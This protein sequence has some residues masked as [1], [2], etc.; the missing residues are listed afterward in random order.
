[1][2]SFL[3]RIF[4][5]GWKVFRSKLLISFFSTL[6][7]VLI[8]VFIWQAVIVNFFINKG[9]GYIE[10]KLDF[11]IYFKD[12]TEQD[13]IKKLQ[14]ILENFPNIDRV[15]LVNKER[16]FEEFKKEIEKNPVIVQAL[17][18]IQVNPLSDYLIVRGQNPKIYEEIANY[19]EGSPYRSLIEFV[20]YAENQKIIQ[21]FIN[22][23]Q[24]IKFTLGLIIVFVG[25]FCA[26][27]I[28]NLTILIIYSQKDEIEVLKLI[29]ASNFFVRSP[30]L[31]FAL[32]VTIFGFLLATLLSIIIIQNINPVF[33]TMIP[34]AD[35]EEYIFGNFWK[36]SGTIFGFLLFINLVSTWL[37]LQKYLKI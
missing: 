26:L 37:S 17:E 2:I 15:M 10:K 7:V 12:G 28:F 27:V 13:D 20:T 35:L 11:S 32:I 3:K 16:A 6:T 9:L 14:A 18:A 29:G 5:N 8:G 19:L 33:L 25:V 31:V 24:K 1:M 4:Q 34:A 22:F 21:K 36:I 30:F 23:S